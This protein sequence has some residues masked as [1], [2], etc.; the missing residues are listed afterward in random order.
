[1]SSLISILLSALLC[2]QA[3]HGRAI[4]ARANRRRVA[5]RQEGSKLSLL[6]TAL[7]AVEYDR[8]EPEEN[9]QF[10]TFIS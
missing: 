8:V 7:Y 6:E 1:M 5:S 9:V 4:F 3:V 2:L 10:Q